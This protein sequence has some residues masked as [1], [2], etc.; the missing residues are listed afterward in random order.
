MSAEEELAKAHDSYRQ[1]AAQRTGEAQ[2]D[3]G[4][5]AGA[6]E[7]AHAERGRS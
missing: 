4:A 2:P 6:A 7:S 3:A 5:R 1:G